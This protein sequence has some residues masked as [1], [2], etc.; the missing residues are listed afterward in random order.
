MLILQYRE[1]TDHRPINISLQ[2]V[3]SWNTG[4]R[5]PELIVVSEGN[6]RGK[7]RGSSLL[8]CT[9]TACAQKKAVY[10]SAASAAV[11]SEI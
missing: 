8:C 6:G 2:L 9:L 3:H 1:C 7:W 10:N 5:L 11:L 4:K